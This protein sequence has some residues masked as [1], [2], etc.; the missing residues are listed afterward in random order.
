M[1]LLLN[2]VRFHQDECGARLNRQ[3][4]HFRTNGYTFCKFQKITEKYLLTPPIHMRKKYPLLLLAEASVSIC[5]A[6]TLNIRMQGFI[7][8]VLPGRG[9]ASL[10]AVLNKY[11]SSE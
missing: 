2:F 5:G 6:G 10:K 8:P 1:L 11:L 3:S 9:P 7:Y 4:S